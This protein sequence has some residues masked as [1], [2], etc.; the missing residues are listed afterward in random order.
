M[1]SVGIDLEEI[2][3]IRKSMQN[4]RFCSRI[5]GETE[6][7]QMKRRGFPAQSVAACFCAKEAFSKAMGTG[8]RGFSL[9]EVELLRGD[10]GRPYL[11]LGGRA[12][13]AAKE[14]KLVFAVSVTHTAKYASAVVIAQ[15]EES[16]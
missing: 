11:R 3:R 2:G 13:E 1:L 16:P 9:R 4:P 15:K 7:G 12:L 6:Y 5:L 14:R 8:V 10:G